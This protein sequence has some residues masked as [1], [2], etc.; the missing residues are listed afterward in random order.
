MKSQLVEYKNTLLAEVEYDAEATGNFKEE[1]FFSITSEKLTEAG[2]LDDVT[3]CAYANTPLGIKIDGFSWN[4]LERI[5]CVV[6][7]EYSGNSKE[8]KRLSKSEVQKIANRPKRFLDNLSRSKFLLSIEP[9]TDAYVCA[10]NYLDLEDKVIKYRVVV[11]TD[12][13]LS[14]RVKSLQLDPIKQQPTTVEVWDLE[15]LHALDKS[16]TETEPFEVST[17]LLGENGLAV[18]HGTTLPSGATTYL[19]VMPGETLSRIYDEFGQRLLEGNVRTFLDFRGGVNRG[20]RNTLVMEPEYFFT[21][22][23]GITLTADEAVLERD[24]NMTKVMKLTNLQIVNGG[25]TTA[26]IYFAP[27]EKGY[28]TTEDGDSVPYRSIAL[29]DVAVPIKLTIFNGSDQQKVEAY[30][31][32]ISQYANKQNSLQ[33]AD[34]V[35]NHPIHRNIERLSRQVLMPPGDTGLTTKWFYERTRGQYSTRLRMLSSKS[36]TKFQAEF[37]KPQAFTKTDMAKY[38]NTW[39]MNPHTVKR[40]AQANLR[41]LGPT[42]VSEYENS[43]EA[44][45]RQFYKDI[46]S[47]AI[48]FKSTDK[49]TLQADW[50][51]AARGLKAEAVTYG[52]ALLRKKLIEQNKDINLER[53]FNQQQL[54]EALSEALIESARI[55]RENLNDQNFLGGV[56]NPSEFCKTEAAWKKIQLLDIPLRLLKSP[57]ILINNANTNEVHTKLGHHVSDL[58]LVFNQGASYWSALAAYNMQTYSLS[59]AEVFIPMRCAM[60]IN[61]GDSLRGPLLKSA[62]E[63]I[64]SAEERGFTY[65]NF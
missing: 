31:S 47:K 28:F 1:S 14:D 58:Q 65:T 8:G 33:E 37:P 43:P 15:R 34:F 39:R 50:Y 23:N 25:Q 2:I 4:P 7:T 45:E 36:K 62:I 13:T 32:R 61:R 49:G 46:V 10:K 41:A 19:G 63:I 51:I 27:K 53:I 54:S 12:S 59:D 16:E 44:F 9:S 26:A 29:T 48:L 57:D 6:V 60:L 5:F 3:T 35:S 42:L 21:Y 17:D 20:L 22:N 55:V 38:E 18:M 52:I 30:R 24:G 64:S 11:L 56:S 40:G